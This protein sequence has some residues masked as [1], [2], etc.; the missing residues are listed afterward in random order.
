MAGGSFQVRLLE[1]WENNQKDG[2]F[3]GFDRFGNK[4][5]KDEYNM[6]IR[7]KH[8][9]LTKRKQYHLTERKM[10]DFGAQGG[11]RTPTPYRH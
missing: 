3:E 9:F 10:V 6:G 1:H 2:L 8:R 5:F 11:T 4:N 7:I